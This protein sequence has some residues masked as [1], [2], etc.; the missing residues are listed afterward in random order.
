[1]TRT[2][3][4]RS[5][6]ATSAADVDAYLVKVPGDKR[7]ALQA[8]R[9]TIRPA[10]PQ[11]EEGMSYGVP[12]FRYLRRPLVAYAAAKDHCSL[13]PM[14]GAVMEAYR[15]ELVSY[16]TSKGTIRFK[17]GEPLPDALVTKLVRA[18]LAETDARSNK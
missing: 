13:F 6:N 7:A 3:T 11:A 12:A 8:L 18:R 16:D 9:E 17:P 15:D 10:V 1:M 14:S 2:S 4:T 5:T